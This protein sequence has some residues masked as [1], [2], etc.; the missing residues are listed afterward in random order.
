MHSRLKFLCVTSLALSVLASC[1][2]INLNPFGSNNKAGASGPQN[3]TAYTCDDNKRFY[4]RMLNQ[5]NDAWLIYP[6]HEVSLAKA[7]ESNRYTSGAITLNL[8]GDQTSLNDG[9]KIAYTG[10]KAQMKK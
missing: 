1:S 2:S 3:A 5:G 9:D 8:N 6:T 7:K 10:C 4:V